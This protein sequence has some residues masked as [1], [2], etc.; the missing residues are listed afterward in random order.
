MSRFE[1]TSELSDSYLVTRC[2]S[3]ELPEHPKH[4]T[5]KKECSPCSLSLQV[6]QR[7]SPAVLGRHCSVLADLRKVMWTHTVA[8]AFSALM[9][10][11]ICCIIEPEQ[12]EVFILQL[13]QNTGMSRTCRVRSSSSDCAAAICK[14][15]KFG[16]WLLLQPQLVGSTV[17]RLRC[18][19][20]RYAD[21]PVA[22]ERKL[23]PARCVLIICAC[24]KPIVVSL[25]NY[26]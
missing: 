11:K 20:C 8:A 10:S 16:R 14:R 5:A 25:S 2:E 1:N 13:W 22:G 24:S 23:C 15:L 26:D 6:A 18:V 7:V 3:R 19:I 9:R 12:Y 21:P 4:S 17:S